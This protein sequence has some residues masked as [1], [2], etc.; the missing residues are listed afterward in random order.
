MKHDHQIAVSES[1]TRDPR[2][3][4]GAE[5]AFSRWGRPCL[6]LLAV[7]FGT[8]KCKSNVL[9]FQYL[10]WPCFGN[11]AICR[12]LALR[13]VFETGV[14][15]GGYWQVPMHF[16][17]FE[18]ISVNGTCSHLS[19]KNL[20]R[21]R[22]TN[23]VIIDLLMFSLQTCCQYSVHLPISTP[24]SC[25]K[26]KSEIKNSFFTHFVQLFWFLV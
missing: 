9:L 23:T 11:R 14:G 6:V 17:H 13:T 1:R 20:P 4:H 24:V 3:W 16:N 15:G 12:G 19:H 22:S 25:H 7:N 18:R 21:P 26:L 2:R 5:A 10:W 8:W